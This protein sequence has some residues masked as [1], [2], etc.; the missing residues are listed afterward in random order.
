MNDGNKHRNKLKKT[1]DLKNNYYI[2]DLKIKFS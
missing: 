1:I 2:T